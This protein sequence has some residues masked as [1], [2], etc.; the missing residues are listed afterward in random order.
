M[1]FSTRATKADCADQR[2]NITDVSTLDL[3]ELAEAMVPISRAVNRSLAEAGV[4]VETACR[5]NLK[6]PNTP[7]YRTT[8]VHM[9]RGVAR[10]RLSKSSDLDG[11]NISDHAGPNTPIHLY[12]G[13]E[14]IRLLHTPNAIAVPAPGT[15]LARRFYYSNTALD[16]LEDSSSLFV[17]HK[18][19]L[20][21]R[22]G[23][24]TGEIALRLVRPIGVWDFGKPAKWDIS[25]NLGGADEDFA[26]YYF[27][28]AE[29]D[30]E[31]PLPNEREAAEEESDASVLS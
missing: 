10:H 14:S 29:D 15:N 3:S 18:Y 24:T 1:K 13:V 30:E 17:Q 26:D 2:D 27:E 25:M 5:E 16:G 31:V 19:L 23:F 20:L 7:E 6:L 21:W 22:E 11:W 12:K 8:R 9:T 28:P 4:D